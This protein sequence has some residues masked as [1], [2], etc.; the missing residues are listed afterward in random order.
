[1]D[2]TEEEEESQQSQSQSQQQPQQSQQQPDHERLARRGSMSEEDARL[3]RAEIKSILQDTS[4][5]P[6]ERRRS[7]QFLM[8]GRRNSMGGA[9]SRRSSGAGASVAS[10]GSPDVMEGSDPPQ[11]MGMTM[12]NMGM[13][14]NMNI[15]AATTTT[16][17]PPQNGATDLEGRV[18]QDHPH[19]PTCIITMDGF[20]HGVSHTAGNE[21]AK[22]AETS[23]PPCTH[24]KRHCTIIAPCCGAAFG[25]RI[26]HDDCPV[27]PPKI[28]PMIPKR[29]YARSS[30]LP[31][32]FTSMDTPEETHHNIDRFAMKEVICRLCFTRQSAKS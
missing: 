8:D 5:E 30:S 6:F 4:I 14:M 9:S 29:R 28:D 19:P 21:Q 3:R 17:P 12:G 25:C 26:C 27:L 7:I 16:G 11:D 13:D 10:L 31:S 24:Y 32:S 22:L 2:D 20:A 23:R 15:H 1:M 18:P